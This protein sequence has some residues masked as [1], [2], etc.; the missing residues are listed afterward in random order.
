MVPILRPDAVGASNCCEGRF[1]IDQNMLCVLLKAK[2]DSALSPLWA[3]EA[4]RMVPGV[5][6]IAE[7]WVTMLFLRPRSES[8]TIRPLTFDLWHLGKIHKPSEQ[9]ESLVVR[10]NWQNEV[11]RCSSLL[12]L[13]HDSPATGRLN[14]SKACNDFWQ[15]QTKVDLPGHVDICEVD[16]EEEL[17]HAAK[18]HPRPLTYL[19]GSL[20][21]R[22]PQRSEASPL[23]LVRQKFLAVDGIIHGGSGQAA[24]PVD[25][26]QIVAG[27]LHSA[28]RREAKALVVKYEESVA[29][30]EPPHYEVAFVGG[31]ES[32]NYELVTGQQYCPRGILF[33]ESPVPPSE[34]PGSP[35]FCISPP[36]GQLNFQAKVVATPAFASLRVSLQDA[37]N[38]AM[39]TLRPLR[40]Q[41]KRSD[42]DKRKSKR[43][44]ELLLAHAI[45]RLRGLDLNLR[46][47]LPDPLLDRIEVRVDDPRTYREYTEL[48]RRSLV[49]EVASTYLH[50]RF[51]LDEFEP[52]VSASMEVKA[53]A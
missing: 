25:G 15:E 8:N 35:Y 46:N 5:P 18:G 50:N 1:R 32:Y 13:V 4:I 49:S 6:S 38:D 51:E 2:R 40:S 41:V 36:L 17:P 3:H 53:T 9:A 12:Q 10:D 39:A 28:I 24:F 43:P 11:M 48:L 26:P 45:Q 7:V 23:L 21:I 22:L 44:Q 47:S 14:L 27:Y 52:T 33:L 20:R 29:S 31:D 34:V 30:Q 37:V 16:W 19:S 42:R